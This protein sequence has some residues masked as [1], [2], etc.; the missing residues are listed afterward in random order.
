MKHHHA[1]TLWLLLLPLPQV[2]AAT[3]CLNYKPTT[4]ALSGIVERR[5]FPGFPPTYES[6]F[7]EES[8]QS[9]WM[10]KLPTPICT[11]HGQDVND[12]PES[13]QREV[14]LVLPQEFHDDCRDAIGAEVKVSGY[15]YHAI[16]DYHHSPLIMVVS[17]MQIQPNPALQRTG[18]SCASTDR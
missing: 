4:I 3:N 11:N 14:Q 10:L 5:E 8:V 17:S 7:G 13:S 12:V 9:F 16:N 1:L 15:F 2:Y 18:R 6:R